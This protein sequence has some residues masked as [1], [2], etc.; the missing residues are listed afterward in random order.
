MHNEQADT[1][2]VLA[3]T[4]AAEESGPRTNSEGKED[5]WQIGILVEEMQ[6]YVA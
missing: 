5:I 1:E 3:A 2:A 6:G 4:A